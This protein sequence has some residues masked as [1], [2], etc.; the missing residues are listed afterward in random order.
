VFGWSLFFH[1][2]YDVWAYD[3]L[4]GLIGLVVLCLV[5]VGGL[6]VFTILVVLGDY[7]EGLLENCWCRKT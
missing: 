6:V 7:F 5:F 1:F 4:V 2:T 3:V